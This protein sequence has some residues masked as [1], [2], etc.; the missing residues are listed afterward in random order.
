MAQTESTA[1]AGLDGIPEAASD[2][3][4]SALTQLRAYLAQAELRPGTRLPAERELSEVLGVS[5]GDLRKALADLEVRGEL[6]RHV[7][8][9][10]F[11]GARP[12]A[13]FFSIAAMA[14]QTNPAEVMRARLVIEPELARE[15]ALHANAEDIET[16]QACVRE[17]RLAESWRQYESWDNRLHRAIA[18]AA[19]NAL[20]L[21]VFDTV[22]AVRRTVVWGR[23]REDR[24]R[25]PVDHH[26]FT[27]HEAI[28]DAIA[29]RDLGRAATSMRLH[30]QT[31]QT[32]LLN[33]HSG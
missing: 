24:Q 5:R 27:E 13:E 25:P 20:L 2:R 12:V 22:N 31:V 7:G 14:A 32:L 28:L 18:E 4:R 26:S 16:L 15:A 23:L 9:G 1:R 11:V 6:W 21:A 30:L 29:E 10:T 33:P 19:H 8:K 17:S 3:G